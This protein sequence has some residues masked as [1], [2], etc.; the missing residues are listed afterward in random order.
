MKDDLK[1][2]LKNFLKK[3]L[4]FLAVA[5]GIV[6]F[7]V[8]FYAI[9]PSDGG[10]GGWGFKKPSGG[11]AILAKPV[12]YLYPEET[13][14]VKVELDI[15]GEL[16]CTYPKYEDGWE[17]TAYPDGTLED[18]K[19][20]NEYSYL[21]WDAYSDI[22]F[23]LSRGFVVKGE[24]T[25]E[26]LRDTLS[27]MGLLPKEYNEF[28]V[29]W[30]PLMEKNDYNFITFQKEAYTDN[31]KLD[32]TPAPDSILRV[33]MVY[34]A[35]DEDDVK[36]YEGIEAPKIKGFERKGFTVVEWGGSEIK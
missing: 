30:L 19:D 3:L 9:F 12:I 2:F 16:Y 31:A 1:Q 36:K 23:D 21:F 26:F 17:V 25:A 29:Y 33:Y 15:S 7:F 35:V 27:K 13:T 6:L 18:K 10:K 4:I 34:T 11:E 22:D 32:I 28:I 8:I 14:D 20:G 5:G 24:D